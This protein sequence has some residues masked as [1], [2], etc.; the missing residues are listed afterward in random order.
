MKLVIFKEYYTCNETA[1]R[2]LERL[3]SLNSPNFIILIS[4]GSVLIFILNARV[5][6]FMKRMAKKIT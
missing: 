3:L 4:E 5:P 6:I 2:L 1:N